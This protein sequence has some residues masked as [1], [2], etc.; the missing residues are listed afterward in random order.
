M[1]LCGCVSRKKK[2]VIIDHFES[3]KGKRKKNGDKKLPVDEAEFT[4][5]LAGKD[6][7][8]VSFSR[9]NR[10]NKSIDSKGLNEP[11]VETIEQANEPLCTAEVAL[12][13]QSGLDDNHRINDNRFNDHR[14]SDL[15]KEYKPTYYRSHHG[16]LDIRFRN[17]DYNKHFYRPVSSQLGIYKTVACNTLPA[18]QC[19][20]SGFSTAKIYYGKTTNDNGQSKSNSKPSALSMYEKITKFKPIYPDKIADEET[21][22]GEGKSFLSK[23]MREDIIGQTRNVR[24]SS[25][26]SVN[27]Q[28]EEKLNS[29]KSNGHAF[30]NKNGGKRQYHRGYWSIAPSDYQ[31]D[32]NRFPYIDNSNQES[33]GEDIR[34]SIEKKTYHRGAWTAHLTGDEIKKTLNTYSTLPRQ[35]VKADD[36]NTLSKGFRSAWSM[37]V[38]G[39]NLENF[40]ANYPPKSESESP[41]KPIKKYFRSNNL[42]S[43]YGTRLE[44]TLE[45]QSKKTNDRETDEKEEILSKN[46]REILEKFDKKFP[47]SQFRFLL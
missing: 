33:N 24:S 35:K 30:S 37:R 1:H 22:N 2:G 34:N 38:T 23:L 20:R 15:E 39:N 26:N 7:S 45:N 21:S 25:L 12:N 27:S 31:V 32:E 8:D 6:E 28:E 36:D 29:L 3:E 17:S 16:T 41:R 9:G 47:N 40:Q 43:V 4:A 42:A 46:R 19:N 10:N 11:E 14:A 5:E 13:N 18:T 44:E